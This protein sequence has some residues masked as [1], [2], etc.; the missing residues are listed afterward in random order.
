MYNLLALIFGEPYWAAHSFLVRIILLAKGIRVGK[1]FRIYGTPYLKIRGKASNIS[2]GDGVFIGG[3]IDLRNREDGSIVIE[4]NAVI[5][6]NCRFVAANKALLRI[7]RGTKIGRDCIFNCGE[8]VTLGEKCILAGMGYVNSSEHT[9]YKAS[10]VRDQGFDHAPIVIEDGVFI[11]GCVSI[12]K[13]ITIGK[14]AVVGANS[15]VTK[16]LPEYSVNVG[17]PARTIKYRK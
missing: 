3:N 6:D 4:D 2:I 1:R 16:D 7:G 13:G 15:V 11:G 10:H 8:D 5:D 9:L 17:V 14:G 12:K